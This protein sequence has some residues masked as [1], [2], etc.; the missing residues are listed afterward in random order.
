MKVKYTNRYKD[1]QTFEVNEK[2]NIQWTA[3]FE[4]S[5]VG[6]SDNQ[7]GITMVVPSGG[8]YIMKGN[9]MGIYDK[10]FYGMIV[11]GFISNDDGYEI[12]VVNR[13]QTVSE[14]IEGNIDGVM[15]KVLHPLRGRIRAEAL[16][17]L[18]AAN[19]LNHEGHWYI[20]LTD[21]VN[22]M[23]DYDELYENES[24]L[25]LTFNGRIKKQLTQEQVEELLKTK[26]KKSK[27]IT[28]ALSPDTGPQ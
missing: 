4:Y 25:K 21:V 12:V 11:K 22:I 6:F 8:P 24:K 5:R 1:V 7:K 2:G 13:V 19:K 20:K 27:T 9:N 3:D 28:G 18:W 17:E 15:D 14:K 23:G 16:D 10:A 26:F